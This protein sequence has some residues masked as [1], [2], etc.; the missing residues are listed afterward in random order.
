VP[1]SPTTAH[2][3]TSRAPSHPLDSRQLVAV[4]AGPGWGKTTFVAEVTSQRYRGWLDLTEAHRDAAALAEA[5]AALGDGERS[6][7]PELA[8]LSDDLPALVRAL[9]EGWARSGIEVV[10]LDDAHVLGGS[11]GEPL[12]RGLAATLQATRLI[13]VSRT[14][15]DLVD[16]YRRGRGD[17]LELNA[18]S[19]ALDLEATVELVERE[20]TPDRALAARVLDASGGW[21]ALSQML[22]EAV[23]P[24][25]PERR[26]AAIDAAC[27]P[28]APVGNYVETVV[29]A[30]EPEAARRMLVRIALLGSAER[31]LLTDGLTDVADEPSTAAM[32]RDLIDDLAM[33]GLVL[34]DPT[35]E[36]RFRLAPAMQ[37][38]VLQHLLPDLDPDGRLIDELAAMLLDQDAVKEAITLLAGHGRIEDTSRLLVEHGPTL[39]RAGELAVVDDSARIVEGA[40][41]TPEVERIHAEAL[42][43]R[44]DW[45]GAMRCLEASGVRDDGPLATDLAL[46]VGLI[47]HL[48]GDLETALAA[49]ARADDSSHPAYAAVCAWRATAHWLRGELDEAREVAA[50]AMQAATRDHDDAGL[51]LAY[52]AAALL[53]ASDGD[54]HA[55]EAYYRQALHA[56]QRAGDLL[57]EAR[58]RTNWGSHHLEEGDYDLAREETERAIDL[59]ERTGFAMIAGVARCNRAEVLLRTGELDQA[60]ADAEQGRQI[61][62]T[63][64]ARTEAYAHHLL[65]FARTERGELTLARQAFDRALRLASPAGDRQALVPAHLGLAAVRSSTDLDAAAEAASKA[66]ELDEG[67]MR[68]EAHLAAAWVAAAKGDHDSS[69]QHALAAREEAT[70]RDNQAAIAEAETCLALMEPDPLP[71][72]RQARLLWTQLD[73][74]LWATRIDL[75]IARRSDDPQE[76][77]RIVWLERRLAGWGCPP[78][79]GSAAHRLLT[80]V[81][82]TPRTQIRA[83]GGFV[84]ER[85]GRPLPPSEWGSRKAQDLLKILAVRSGRGTSREELAHLLWPDHPYD[86]VSNRLSTALSLA[87]SALSG[88]GDANVITTHHGTIRLDTE[89]VDIDVDTFS[90]FAE[91]GLRAARAADEG[92]ALPLLLQAEELYGGDLLEDDRD[93]SWAE[94]RRLSLRTSYLEVARTIA[95]LS[96]DDDP[97]LS[98]RMLL[99]I[100]DR[101]PYDEPAHLNLC[102]ALLRSG[103]HGEARRRFRLY[104][105][106]M[107]ELDLPLVPFHELSRE[108]AARPNRAAS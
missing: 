70:I 93:A 98:I 42:A 64:G 43:F 11:S 63:V 33:R 17:V 38:V 24:V 14:E 66:I 5:L 79:R 55:N 8:D 3:H 12:I 15:L 106:R 76:R 36:D 88:G 81:D 34:P 10:V 31:N 90:R 80:A 104:E 86:D 47:H 25:P 78:D 105:E 92:A 39:I 50:E 60:I 49:Y 44:G 32:S 102:L 35:S 26:S 53:A 108:A 91:D 20:L 67:M 59:A 77:A 51:A 30:G 54:R 82:Q 62:A 89:H 97:D 75:G 29:L 2:G 6:P 103:G 73:A 95:R 94:D 101:D 58:I 21:P 13:V 74:P 1:P 87:R 22:V 23:R 65:G 96:A 19:L 57:Q 85:G 84:V 37:R 46:Q 69:R 7:A 9:D 40:A 16:A 100:L 18:R 52:T 27:D 107:R 71:G 83:L 99:R 41:R 4:V 68:A 56:A 45:V 48:R 72:L 28:A 61:F